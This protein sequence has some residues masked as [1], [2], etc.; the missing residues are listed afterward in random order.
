MSTASRASSKSP[1]PIER[2]RSAQW[3][4]DSKTL[5]V[6]G[7]EPSRAPRCY[8][9]D[10][11][12]SAPKPVTSEGVVGSLAPD[13][14]TLLLTL[15]NGTFQLGSIDGGGGQP[16]VGLRADDI[17]IAWGRDS[18]SLF[19]QHGREVP[20]TIE[21]V[22]LTTGHRTIVH[23]LSPEGSGLGSIASVRIGGWADDGRWYAYDYWSSAATL[24][25]VSG[26]P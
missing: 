25:V 7:S 13:G 3:F 21:R 20:A 10:V 14:R 4:P 16:V 12:G 26:A 6:C 17:R 5:L 2:Y 1:G 19:I 23:Q 18:R 22:E 11:A 24:F 15:P 8:I 9:Q